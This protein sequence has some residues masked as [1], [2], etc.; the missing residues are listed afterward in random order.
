MWDDFA[1]IKLS[2]LVATERREPRLVEE[3]PGPNWQAE[4]EA[5]LRATRRQA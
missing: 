3:D 5:A 4:W 2:D 1:D